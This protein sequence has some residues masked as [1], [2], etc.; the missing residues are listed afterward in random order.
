MKQQPYLPST[1]DLL[2][3]AL[4]HKSRIVVVPKDT[5]EM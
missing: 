4:G 1:T 3:H 5:Q 2:W